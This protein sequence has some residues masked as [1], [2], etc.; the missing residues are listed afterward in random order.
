[1]A[2]F[3]QFTCKDIDGD[4]ILDALKSQRCPEVDMFRRLVVNPN[5][6]AREDVGVADGG[7]GT[8]MVDS[9]NRK[10]PLC[11]LA[12][13]CDVSI[14]RFLGNVTEKT[15]PIAI[16]WALDYISCMTKR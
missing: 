9:D 14:L 13:I 3:A 1:M 6:I 4:L 7:E 16:H 11:Q 12:R 5:F 15:P 8:E 10:V 2:I